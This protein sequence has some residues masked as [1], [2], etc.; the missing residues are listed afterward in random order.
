MTI[1]RN[2]SLQSEIDRLKHALDD[3]QMLRKLEYEVFK[4]DRKK[5]S[6]EAESKN[7][8]IEELAAKLDP[9][10]WVKWAGIGAM[11]L[12]IIEAIRLVLE[13]FVKCWW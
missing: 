3:C 6:A 5:M 1:S 2:N 8:K 10:R 12:L 11:G 9:A 13:Y 4:D 7:R